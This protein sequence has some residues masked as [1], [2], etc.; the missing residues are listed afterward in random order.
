MKFSGR[1][2][3]FSLPDI[4]RILIQSQKSGCLVIHYQNQD[5]RIF[6]NQGAL[7]HAE[8]PSSKGEQAVFEMLNFTSTA[9]F[10]FIQQDEMP[11]P[12]QTIFSDLDPLIQKGIASLE[13]WRKLNRKFARISAQTE[14]V[15][16][17]PPIEANSS[18]LE[19]LKNKRRLA[20]QV[21]VENLD[22]SPEE[23]IEALLEFEKN[24]IIRIDEEEAASM[25]R[26][27][28]KTANTALG[29]FNSISGLKLKQEMNER[30]ERL[31]QDKNWLIEI[32]NGMIVDDKIQSS[33]LQTQS[34]QYGLFL[35]QLFGMISPIYGKSFLQQVMDKVEQ[36]L[37]GS[38]QYWTK[39]LK[40]EL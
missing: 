28:R 2:A 5:S 6:V 34:E 17:K 40:L 14:I 36:E 18:I 26:F 19:L 13:L 16:L 31:I 1:F 32:Q 20:V 12:T 7:H 38:V 29:E 23:I 37:P 33:S 25:R 30:L 22:D 39:E 9:E 27:F 3:D 35:T 21:L 11:M 8:S 10:D 15:L 24:G 4:L